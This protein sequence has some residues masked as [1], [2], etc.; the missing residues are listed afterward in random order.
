MSTNKLRWGILGTAEIARKNWVAIRHSG[1]STLVAVASREAQ[2]SRRFIE[3]CQSEAP[4]EVAP[5]PFGRYEDVLESDEVDAV[6]IPLPTGLRKEWVLRAAEAGKHVLCEKPCATSTADLREMLAACRHHRVQF[7]DGVMFTHSRRLERL[8]EVLEDGKSVGEVRRV[9]SAFSFHAP[10]EFF[11]SNIRAHSGLEPHG[12]LGDLG[13]YCIR[14]SLWVMNWQ[15]PRQVTGR[16]LS[17]LG[18]RDSPAPVPAEFSGELLFEGGVSAGFY[19][20]FLAE[21]QQWAIISGTRGYV[22]MPDF[23]LPFHGHELSFEV[24]NATYH[25]KGCDFSM[26]AKPR[27]CA[28][29]EYSHAHASAPESSLFRNFANQALSGRLNGTWPEMALKTQTVM[30]ACLDS[31]SANS[32]PVEPG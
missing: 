4:F 16:I 6:Y 23:V 26:E 12:C 5:K 14:L 28:V 13:W 27:R 31:A 3:E 18:R 17:E 25:I 10:P 11:T 20:S 22:R 15:M 9:A 7:M 21:H 19:C 29:A 24:L 1:N 8:R 2:R 30:G 32:R